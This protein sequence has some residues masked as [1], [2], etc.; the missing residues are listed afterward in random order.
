M[1]NSLNRRQ[2]TQRKVAKS[3]HWHWNNWTERERSSI[4]RVIR[5]AISKSVQSPQLKS[6]QR[7]CSITSVKL[8]KKVVKMVVIGHSRDRTIITWQMWGQRTNQNREFLNGYSR[9]LWYSYLCMQ[10]DHSALGIL[11]Q[12]RLS[13][14]IHW[15][16]HGPARKDVENECLPQTVWNWLGMRLHEQL[17][18]MQI[19]IYYDFSKDTWKRLVSHLKGTV[20]K[21]YF[22]FQLQRDWRYMY[23][24]PP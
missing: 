10:M 15:T 7:R 24:H 20:S 19:F 23:Q 16:E 12:A 21:I 14:K 3:W 6:D 1:L 9:I 22:H 13:R 17:F 11:V 8:Q 18:S 4:Q 5:R 2:E